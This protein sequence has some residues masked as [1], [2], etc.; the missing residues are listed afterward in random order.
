VRAGDGVFH[1][2]QPF[3][4]RSWNVGTDACQGRGILLANHKAASADTAPTM[5][6]SKLLTPSNLADHIATLLLIS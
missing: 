3:L 2:E 1:M 6:D 4:V 5:A